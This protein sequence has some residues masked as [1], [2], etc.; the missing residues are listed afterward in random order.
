MPVFIDMVACNS[1][2]VFISQQER[3]VFFREALIYHH[4]AGTPPK[5]RPR[6]PW[7][8]LADVG[9]IMLLYSGPNLITMGLR[10]PAG[11]QY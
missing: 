7:L 1:A 11:I 6:P 2:H 3:F 8:R 4:R 5:M 9:K 10:A